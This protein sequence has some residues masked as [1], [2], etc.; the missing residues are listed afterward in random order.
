MS[1][2]IAGMSLFVAVCLCVIVVF[3]SFIIRELQR[4]NA[5]HEEYANPVGFTNPGAYETYQHRL[6]QVA[7]KR[8]YTAVLTLPNGAKVDA[9]VYSGSV[10]LNDYQRALLN[11]YL[12]LSVSEISLEEWRKTKTKKK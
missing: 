6:F 7:K 12:Q 3:Q 9:L 10:N 11:S 2:K 8:G 4:C 1:T 5:I